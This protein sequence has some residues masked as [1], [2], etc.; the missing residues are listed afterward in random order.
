MVGFAPASRAEYPPLRC[1]DRFAATTYSEGTML[2]A[3][4][5]RKT[6]TLVLAAAIVACASAARQSASPANVCYP[7]QC[8]LDVQ[9][10]N[11]LLIGVRYYDSTGVGDVL[12]SVHSGSVRRFA[13]SRRTSRTITVE[14]SRDKEIYRAQTKLL[15]PPFEN[16]LH[17]PTDF[18][19]TSTR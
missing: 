14:V 13:L 18:E 12:G 16:V 15:L 1:R 2:G 4:E 8:F 6:A 5:T 11:G 3:G 10:D 9:N 19:T 7:R 17:F